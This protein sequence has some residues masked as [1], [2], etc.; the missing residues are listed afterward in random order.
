MKISFDFKPWFIGTKRRIPPGFSGITILWWVFYLKSD[1][2]EAE[3]PLPGEFKSHETIHSWQQTVLFVLGLLACVLTSFICGLLGAVT[4]W[5]VWTF[6]ATV[7]FVLYALA[8]LVEVAL[9]PYDRAY[10][11][12]IFEREAYLNQNDPD[13]VPDVFSVWRY[14]RVNRKFL[15]GK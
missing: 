14:F 11:D 6:P 8:W 3:T 5:W 10:Y 15:N 13:Y 2:P 1:V 4:P 9:P 7:P 12:S